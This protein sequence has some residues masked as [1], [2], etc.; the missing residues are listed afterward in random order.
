MDRLTAADAGAMARAVETIRAGKAAVERMIKDDR[1][2]LERRQ[3]QV[4]DGTRVVTE[5]ADRALTK[6]QEASGMAEDGRSVVTRLA[7]QTEALREH[8]ESFINDMRAA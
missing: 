2:S 5:H 8:L 7:G 6:A 4:N 3:A 1:T